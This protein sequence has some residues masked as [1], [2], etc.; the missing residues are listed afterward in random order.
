MQT[1]KLNFILLFIFL[2]YSNLT[3]SQEAPKK[4]SIA[5]IS[6]LT[7]YFDV[8]PR[9]FDIVKLED[10]IEKSVLF[11]ENH[12]RFDNTTSVG[13]QYFSTRSSQFVVGLDLSRFN[14]DK[15]WESM[16]RVGISYQNFRVNA[17]NSYNRTGGNYDTL[18][19]N[20]N[21]GYIVRDTFR[22][23]SLQ[24]DME[25][26]LLGFDIAWTLKK[27]FKTRWHLYSGIG[28]ISA[29]TINSTSRAIFTD[30]ITYRIRYGWE[31][32]RQNQDYIFKSETMM[33]EN[34]DNFFIYMPF[35]IEFQVGKDTREILK[36]LHICIETRPSLNLVQ[37]N[38]NK[39]I[40]NVGFMNQI[41]LRFTL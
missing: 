15:Q 2:C 39:M 20:V 35:G 27:K 16:V 10:L 41:G 11:N 9:H 32:Y 4:I 36:N 6:V 25:N 34:I 40:S 29:F 13:S 7:G 22:S 21:A 19:S 17:W 12:S 5:D 8:Y 1:P 23:L 18:F 14:S 31:E 24:Y 38:G 28:L 3:S 26:N 33:G 37:I 30:N